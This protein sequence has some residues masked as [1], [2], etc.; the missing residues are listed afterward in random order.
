MKN[1]LTLSIFCCGLLF[2]CG[3][4]KKTAQFDESLYDDE[5]SEILVIDETE[6][7]ETISQDLTLENTLRYENA[8]YEPSIHSVQLHPLRFEMGNPLIH[9]SF[10]DSLLL[11]FDDLSS[12]PQ[13]YAYTLIHCNADWTPS[14]LMENEYLEGFYE[15]PITDYQ[16]SFNTIQNYVHYQTVIPSANLKPSL[17]GNYLLIVFPENQKDQP[18]LSQR[19]MIMDEKVSVKGSVKRA[20]D[21]EQRNYQHE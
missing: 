6:V 5:S 2:S 1:T 17:S 18:I 19:M 16:F 21:L 8:I 15:E 14:D 4:S 3:G 13:N 9:L 12:D 20:T 11:S 7:D 10:K